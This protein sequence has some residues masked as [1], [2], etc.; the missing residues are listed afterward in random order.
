MCRSIFLYSLVSCDLK[1]ISVEII[2]VT[3][4]VQKESHLAKTSRKPSE[5]SM[6]LTY[7]P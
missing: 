5:K 3:F 2:A 6:A 7:K 1:F 4:Y